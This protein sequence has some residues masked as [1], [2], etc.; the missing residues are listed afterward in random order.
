MLLV[1]AASSDAEEEPSGLDPF[2]EVFSKTLQ[3]INA[4]WE[5]FDAATTK[6]QEVVKQCAFLSCVQHR[7]GYFTALHEGTRGRST[8]AMRVPPLPLVVSWLGSGG[9]DEVYSMSLGAK[10]GDTLLQQLLASGKQAASDSRYTIPREV[11]QLKARISLLRDFEDITYDT[12]SWTPGVDGLWYCATVVAEDDVVAGIDAPLRRLVVRVY[13][14]DVAE[15]L[16]NKALIAT[17]TF[18]APTEEERLNAQSYMLESVQRAVARELK[19]EV[20]AVVIEDY[21]VFNF[22][23]LEGECPVSNLPTMKS[24]TV[25]APSDLVRRRSLTT[26]L[27]FIDGQAPLQLEGA[28]DE[29]CFGALRR[30]GDESRRVRALLVPARGAYDGAHLSLARKL[31]NAALRGE[32]HPIRRVFALASAWD[33]FIDGC[34]LPERRCAWYG[35]IPLDLVVLDKLRSSKVFREV[36]VEQDMS[37]RAIEVLLPVIAALRDG[38]EEFTLVPIIVGGLDHTTVEQYARVLQPYVADESNLF[39]VAGD[40]RELGV[41]PP[42]GA[43]SEDEAAEARIAPATPPAPG[44][45]RFGK[46]LAD[47]LDVFLATLMLPEQQEEFRLSHFR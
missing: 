16:Y 36:L 17:R 15:R 3:E 33:A 38:D 37:E 30:V 40:L 43:A 41:A 1:L 21:S 12:T 4:S 5:A 25:E 22:K 27:P 34:G 18:R 6:P 10:S 23:V 32:L 2:V 28:E 11:S 7:L 47:A 46:A 14:P 20:P 8:V 35:E 24:R 45:V 19:G 13:L 39:V 31:E 29:S 26:E 9:L 42:V 44:E